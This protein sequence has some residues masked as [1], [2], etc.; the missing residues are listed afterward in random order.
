MGERA[1]AGI[2]ER[3]AFLAFYDD[4]FPQ[5]YRY[6]SLRCHGQALAEDLTADTFVAAV[7]AFR[8]AESPPMTLPWVI[9]VARHKLVDHWRRQARDDRRFELLA[10][11]A[12]SQSFEP[13]DV[14]LNALSVRR[15]MDRIA[16]PQQRFSGVD[17]SPE[18]G[19]DFG[20]M[21]GQPGNALRHV[22]TAGRCRAPIPLDPKWQPRGRSGL[23]HHGVAD[24][25]RARAYYGSV[26]GWHFASGQ[27][28]DG[29]Q[30]NNVT[31]M[32]GLSGGHE[33][34]RTV[35]M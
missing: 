3:A 11:T 25:A 8:R 4:A 33:A 18:E 21:R 17:R 9:G 22:R 27:L 14:R 16:A 10:V 2:D 15:T 35:P 31:P 32:V 12:T 6:F 34:A 1:P 28:A 13:W 19:G 30:V 23:H 26:L 7:D 24:S 20:Q 5:V 29:W